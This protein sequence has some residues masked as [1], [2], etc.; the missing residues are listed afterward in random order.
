MSSLTSHDAQLLLDQ[1]VSDDP[2]AQASAR[3]TLMAFDEEVVDPLT[4]VFH[5]G[6]TESIGMVIIHIVGEIGGPDA[7]TFLRGV[8]HFEE[9]QV[10]WKQAAAHGLLHNRDN[11]DAS[12]VADVSAFLAGSA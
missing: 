11:L 3:E 2:A 1:L 4:T 10:V 12:E 8:Y 9:R 6:T 7:L 5:S